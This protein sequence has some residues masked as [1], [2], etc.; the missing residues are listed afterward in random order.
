MC[1]LTRAAWTVH[2]NCYSTFAR[3]D[4]SSVSTFDSRSALVGSS[5][6]Y[7][8]LAG[9]AAALAA[10][11]Q[12]RFTSVGCCDGNFLFTSTDCGGLATS[13]KDG[14]AFQTN[15]FRLLFINC[16][17]SKC[18]S[19]KQQFLCTYFFDNTFHCLFSNVHFVHGQWSSV[20]EINKKSVVKKWQNHY[21]NSLQ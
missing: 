7:V 14:T 16:E 21:S 11:E 4:R 15:L 3:T 17:S 2:N 19:H 9:V 13:N 8:C 12:L 5:A 6:P 18:L 1:V 10:R 20:S